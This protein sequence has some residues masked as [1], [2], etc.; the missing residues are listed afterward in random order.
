MRNKGG[1]AIYTR[2]NL[3]VIDIYRSDLYE[4]LCLT[5]HLPTG[6]RMLIY[7]LYHPPK[8][9]YQKCELI[10]Y[11][12]NLIDNTLDKHPN[13]VIVC[14]GDLNQI[15]LTQLQR[16]T[17]LSVLVDFPTRAESSLDNCLTNRP[18]LFGKSYPINTQMKTDHL[19][20]TVPA[21]NKLKP[22]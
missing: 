18:Y 14:G 15:N 11:L 13:K 10:H 3:S 22:L 20:F 21:G 12:V 1:V 17:A 6:H 2:N 9:R 5:L 19:G 16:L 7:G 4:L 8:F